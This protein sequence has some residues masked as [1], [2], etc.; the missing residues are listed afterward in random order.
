MKIVLRI[1]L[2]IVALVVL[3]VVALA[4]ILLA[5]G[6]HPA[7]AVGV[8]SVSA[9]D[10]GHKSVSATVFY[11]TTAKPRAM[12]LTTGFVDLAPH[13][14]VAPGS[15]PMVVISHGTG[16]GPM[17]HLDTAL[18]LAS[19]GYI[20]VAPTH[21]G[22]NFQDA[23]EVGTSDWIVDRA[24]QIVRVDDYMLGAWKDHAS[25]DPTRIGLF[26]FSAGATTGL[27][28]IGGEPDFARLAPQCRDHPEFVCKLMKPG[29]VRVPAASEWAHDPRVKSAVIVAPGF[30]FTFE[31]KGLSGVHAQVQLWD[32]DA[33]DSVPLATNTE[34]VKRLLP[35]PPDYHVVHGA[36]HFS[37]LTPCGATAPLLPPML[38]KDPKGF[39]RKAFHRDFDAAVVGFFDRTLAR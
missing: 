18:A 17:S 12:F 37:F 30:G 10:A 33:D 5:S 19:A 32:G 27:V 38:C 23:S 1:L 21:N 29:P 14:A 26:G 28:V 6:T 24:R 9:P 25:I 22:D 39:D 16:G 15:H 8:Q 7:H 34:T 36:A 2:W 11:P 4:A 31:P 35:L 3:G 13:G 20:V